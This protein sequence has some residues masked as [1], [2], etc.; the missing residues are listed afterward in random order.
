MK[1]HTKNSRAQRTPCRQQSFELRSA[2]T[3][4]MTEVL[5]PAGIPATTFN[6]NVLPAQIVPGS[7]AEIA[8]EQSATKVRSMLRAGEIDRRELSKIRFRDA[9]ADTCQAAIEFVS[10]LPDALEASIAEAIFKASGWYSTKWRAA[11]ADTVAA[12]TR[13]VAE[14]AHSVRFL[15]SKQTALDLTASGAVA[16]EGVAA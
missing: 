3:A 6:I 9:C 4:S 14:V 16:V 5:F 7:A 8:V 12:I 10:T 11:T 13:Y 1:N 2:P 15:F